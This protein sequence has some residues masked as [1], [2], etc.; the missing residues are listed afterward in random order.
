[1]L[2]LQNSDL[3]KTMAEAGAKKIGFLKSVET[4]YIDNKKLDVIESL[5]VKTN[6]FDERILQKSTFMQDGKMHTEVVPTV[7]QHQAKLNQA[8][9]DL[10]NM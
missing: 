2:N 8:R 10:R 1:M 5:K 3:N 6:E 7:Y 9:K 4:N